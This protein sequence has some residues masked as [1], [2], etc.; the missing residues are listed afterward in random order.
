M[1]GSVGLLICASGWLLPARETKTDDV[2][3]LSFRKDFTCKCHVGKRISES[4][5]IIEGT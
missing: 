4:V 1:P 3:Y 5:Y 2:F